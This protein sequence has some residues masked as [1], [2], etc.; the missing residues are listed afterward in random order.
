MPFAV[1][2]IWREPKDHSSDYYFC[3]TKTTSITSKSRHTVE[4][5][6]LSSAMRPVPHSDI[7]PMPQPS[8]NTNLKQKC[9]SISDAKIKEGIFVGTQILEL[10]QDGNFQ[11]SLNGVKAAAWKSFGN[12]EYL[13]ILESIQKFRNYLSGTKEHQPNLT[14]PSITV[15]VNGIHTIR[16]KGVN[17]IIIPEAFQHLLMNQVHNEYNHPG[18]IKLGNKASETQSKFNEVMTLLADLTGYIR[19]GNDLSGPMEA[20]K[21][22]SQT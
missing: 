22:S 12:W 11:N 16:R 10:L 8:E 7:L 19:K 15:D 18:L 4:Y 17:R 20:I 14:D 5:P 9:Y 2:M 6:D 1:P 3:L 21:G 13:A